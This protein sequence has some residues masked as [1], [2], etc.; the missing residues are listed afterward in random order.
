M[1][2]LE[3]A[4]VGD[5]IA[6]TSNSNVYGSTYHGTLLSKRPIYVWPVMGHGSRGLTIKELCADETEYAVIRLP[7]YLRVP[8]FLL[9]YFRFWFGHLR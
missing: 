4:R 7:M 2:D 5:I 3:N 6:I 8:N 1:I 9:S